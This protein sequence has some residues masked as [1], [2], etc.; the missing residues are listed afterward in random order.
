MKTKAII[1]DL[2]GTAVNSPLEKLP[3]ASLKTAVKNLESK[4]Y[5][6]S[7]TGRVWTFA[8]PVLQ[9]LNLVDPCIISAGTQI[10][11]PVTGKIL[12]Q[13]TVADDSLKQVIAILKEY[14]DYKLLYNDNDEHEYFYGGMS[15]LDFAN[16]EPVYFLEQVFVPD[17]TAIK[18]HEQ[19]NGI[20]GITCVMVTAQKPG[21]R[22]LHIIN[23]E[24]TKEHAV[25]ELLKML[26]IDKKNT[27]GIG[28]GHNDVHLFNAV[29]YKVAMGNAVPD[30]K[31]VANIVIGPVEQDG[32]VKYL[33][34][35]S[36]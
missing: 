16:K 11:N 23:N 13:K 21:T 22:D 30:L 2:D 4:Y 35:L 9:E 25:A 24:A 6:S 29:A 1:F 12:W 36:S 31:A 10:C 18:I 20:P 5:L 34:S 15:P 19:L 28:D 14:P 27:I 8:K 33:Q 26:Q 32:L 7:A 3:P 17:N